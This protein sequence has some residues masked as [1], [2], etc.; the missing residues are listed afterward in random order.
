[1]FIAQATKY[2]REGGYHI[3]SLGDIKNWYDFTT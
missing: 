1:M 3:E 2:Y